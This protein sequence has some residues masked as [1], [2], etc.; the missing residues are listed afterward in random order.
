M[1]N[2]IPRY[3][4]KKLCAM[5][6]GNWCEHR[7]DV[8]KFFETKPEGEFDFYGNPPPQFANSKMWKGKVPGQHSGPEKIVVLKNYRFS[9]CYENT[10]TEPGYI[11][12]K[13]FGCFAAGCVPVYLGATNVEVY[14]PKDC[15]IDRRDFNSNEEM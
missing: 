6:S 3:E 4:D 13:I 9:M 11:S 2:T 15:F 7:F 8:L 14:I 10:I 12:E 1:L 5:F